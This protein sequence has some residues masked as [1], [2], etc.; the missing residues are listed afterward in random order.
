MGIVIKPLLFAVCFVFAGACFLAQAVLLAT[1]RSC[2]LPARTPG[3]GGPRGPTPLTYGT[4]HWDKRL[5]VA[6]CGTVRLSD[7]VG[8]ASV[9]RRVR[10]RAL[11]QRLPT[12]HHNKVRHR[13]LLDN[14]QKEF[15]SVG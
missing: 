8:P 6:S 12:E 10:S 11:Q 4:N 2:G 9:P 7:A 3:W 13:Q 14:R 1:A 15:L 5:V